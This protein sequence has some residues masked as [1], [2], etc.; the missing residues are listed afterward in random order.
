M[1]RRKVVVDVLDALGEPRQ[2]T[3][4]AAF[5]DLVDFLPRTDGPL[6]T[7]LGVKRNAACENGVRTLAGI[8][9]DVDRELL[10]GNGEEGFAIR[11]WL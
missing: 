10:A 4:R 1:P 5:V 9:G 11:G 8:A 6:G 2:R 3:E 7:S